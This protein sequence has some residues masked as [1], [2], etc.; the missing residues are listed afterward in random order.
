[1]EQH[2]ANIVDV[3]H[4]AFLPV[5]SP[6][7]NETNWVLVEIEDLAKDLDRL[8]LQTDREVEHMDH[9]ENAEASDPD[10]EILI[11]YGSEI[12]YDDI[13]G[14]DNGRDY[15]TDDTYPYCISIE[16]NKV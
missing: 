5:N 2:C 4:G 14:Y 8:A 9:P 7:L 3:S 13:I 16:L 1:V 10:D 15:S 12:N 11:D 6:F